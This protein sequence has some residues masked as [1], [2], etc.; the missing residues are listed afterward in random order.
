M[1]QYVSVAQAARKTARTAEVIYRAIRAGKLQTLTGTDGT[2]KVNLDEAL[3]YSNT[4]E[5]RAPRRRRVSM[6]QLASRITRERIS[7]EPAASV[8]IAPQV[9][10]DLAAGPESEPIARLSMV[11]KAKFGKY[12]PPLA[13]VLDAAVDLVIADIEGRVTVR[14]AA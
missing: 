12:A 3:A 11:V 8:N 1:T 7:A 6:Q 13:R 4:L 2:T 14:E 10:V 5:R 9:V